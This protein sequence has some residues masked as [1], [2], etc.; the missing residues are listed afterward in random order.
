MKIVSDIPL[1]QKWYEVYMQYLKFFKP[2]ASLEEL[3]ED[4]SVGTNAL[5][6]YFNN[7]RN[8]WDNDFCKCLRAYIGHYERQNEHC[9]YSGFDKLTK[10]EFTRPGERF[11]P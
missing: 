2:E 7:T 5:M 4:W 9:V 8:I 1:I 6:E 3:E 10:P 11:L